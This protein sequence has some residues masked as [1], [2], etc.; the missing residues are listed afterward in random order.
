MKLISSMKRMV[1]HDEAMRNTS[2]TNGKCRLGHASTVDAMCNRLTHRGI[3]EEGHPTRPTDGLDTKVE[4]LP[5]AT[6]TSN[7]AYAPGFKGPREHGR[8]DLR[9]EISGHNIAFPSHQSFKGLLGRV[10]KAKDHAIEVWQ[11]LWST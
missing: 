8:R 5:F 2:L 4:M 9:Q 3:R 11:S 6:W 10:D 7:Q 1:R